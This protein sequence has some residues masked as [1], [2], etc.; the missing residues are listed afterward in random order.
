MKDALDMTKYW[1]EKAD[2]LLLNR[3][4]ISV[5]WQ[6]WDENELYEGTGLVF[7]TDNDVVFFLGQDDEGNGPGALHWVSQVPQGKN[8]LLSGVLPTGVMDA[9]KY[10]SKLRESLK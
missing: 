10:Q 9:K 5:A 3:K 1:Y 2:N 4:I 7:R 6:T 8:K